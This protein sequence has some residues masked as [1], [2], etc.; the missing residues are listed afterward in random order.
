M[1]KLVLAFAA[2]YLGLL[3]AIASAQTPLKWVTSWA[4]SVQGP[5]TRSVIHR[6][7]RTSALRFRSRR[8]ALATKLFE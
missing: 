3:P 1:A 8:T 4:G 7:S 2:A 6:C 5:C